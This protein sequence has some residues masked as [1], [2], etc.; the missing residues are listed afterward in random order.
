LQEIILASS[1]PRRKEIL[2]DLGIP[3]LIV[4]SSINE[5]MVLSD[6]L[7]I[8]YDLSNLAMKLSFLKA[9][10][11]AKSFPNRL[12]LGA[13]TFVAIQN[14]ILGKPENLHQ[15]YEYLRLLSGKVHQVITG[16]SIININRGY[17]LSDYD[18]TNVYVKDLLENDIK[19]YCK[20]ENVLDA[21]GAYKIQSF[22]TKYVDKI[23]GFY[24]TVMGLPVSKVYR[25]IS[26][27]YKT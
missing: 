3:H 17:C 11:V 2:E 22:L 7:K 4:A 21:A 1:S 14:Q 15:A 5:E 24:H 25:A 12:V 9:E 6:N 23:E 10:C 26:Y 27:F 8:N 20:N 13:D 16:F 18:L 19:D